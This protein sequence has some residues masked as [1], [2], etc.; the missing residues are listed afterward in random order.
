MGTK[1]NLIFPWL[2]VVN[3][4]DSFRNESNSGPAN[5]QMLKV[6][7]GACPDAAQGVTLEAAA[8][9]MAVDD[10]AAAVVEEL[11][12]PVVINSAAAAAPAVSLRA[13]PLAPRGQ[14][15]IDPT[16]AGGKL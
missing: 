6:L 4:G 15:P 14:A 8:P 1:L 9:V 16:L 12:Q 5:R 7:S 3:C 2:S 11:E 10:G 13:R